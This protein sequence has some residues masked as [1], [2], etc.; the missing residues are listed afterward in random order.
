[1]KK[2]IIILVG[3]VGSVNAFAQ[4]ASTKTFWDDP[5][6][7][8]DLPLFVVSAFVFIVLLLVIITS[9]I[10]LRAF[11]TLVEQTE[12]ERA[13]AQGIVYTPK[14]SFFSKISQKLNDSV[15][16]EKEKDIDMGHDFDGIRELDN[17]LPPWWKWLFY[18]TIGWSAVYI[19]LFHF[20]GSLPLMQEEYEEEVAIA[21]AAKKAFQASQP[22]A[23]IDLEKLVFTQDAEI[24]ARGR[25]VFAG[26]NCGSCHRAD[27]GGN[28]IGPNLTDEY[29]IHGGDMKKVFATIK[30]GFVE[31]G[32]PAWGKALSPTEVRDVTFFVMSLQGSNPP[33][34]KAPQGE[35]FK[36]DV[37]KADTVKAQASL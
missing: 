25:T 32:M 11:N 21:E 29:W 10:L 35:L 5:F 6:T 28:T 17:H 34:A 19:F 30:D 3:L 2:I 12:R 36:M 27:G 26:N 18:G 22:Q 24:I 20:S 33:N 37:P 16:L 13:K 15:P 31:K 23:V 1:M 4:E 8:P 7:H 9:L 14:P